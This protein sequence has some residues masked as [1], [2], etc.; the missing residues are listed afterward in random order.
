MSQ[1]TR[2]LKTVH[3][4]VLLIFVSGPAACG[5][6]GPTGLPNA[7]D[8]RGASGS[9]SV[10]DA[11]TVTA[12]GGS[13]ERGLS[14]TTPAPS[15]D[16]P[17]DNA[18]LAAGAKAM[19]DKDYGRA[20]GLFQKAVEHGNAAAMCN[21]GILYARGLGMPQDDKKAMEW[22][23][24]A[25]ARG[26]AYAMYHIGVI[27]GTGGKGIPQDYKEAMNWYRKAAVG[28]NTDA[29]T[30][31]GRLYCVGLGV[32]QDCE[33]GRKWYEKAAALGNSTAM[34]NLGTL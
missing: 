34:V 33:E 21:I 24:K 1:D 25:A 12:I 20:T 30:N 10:H 8:T 22:F 15:D 6:R 26:Y 16:D 32:A 13:E 2:I 9:N 23:Q 7:Q 17:R 18:D 14:T 19:N 27:Y 3:V 31:L 29:M 5:R 11:P 4:A 28:G